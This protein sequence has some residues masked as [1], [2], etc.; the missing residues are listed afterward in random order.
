MRA[1]RRRRSSTSSATTPPITFPFDAPLTT[2]IDSLAR[3]MSNFVRR[4]ASA[5]DVGPG[6]EAA[7]CAAI[8][9]PG[10]ATLILPA[11]AAWG[12]VASTAPAPIAITPPPRVDEAVIADVAAAIAAAGGR[13]GLLLAGTA[14]RGAA[15]AAAGRIAAKT[16]ARLFSE[17]LIARSERGNG[18][19]PLERIP[20]PIDQARAVLADLSVLILVGAHEP[21]AFFAYPGKPSRLVPDGC[22]VV[23]LAEAGDAMADALE[24]LADRLGA[25]AATAP[26]PRPAAAQGLPTGPLT[27]DAVS[28]IA[29]AFL[30]EGAIVCDE[31]L[32]SGRR[33][34]ALSESGPQHDYLM[35]TGGAIGIG[36]P[37]SVGAAVACPDRKVVTLQADG[38]GMYTLQ[39]L[40]TT[41]REQLDIVVVVFANHAYA[42]LRAEMQHVGVKEFGRNADRMLSL[43]KPDLD[44]V[45][46]ARGMGVE[47]ARADSCEGFADLYRQALGRRGP[48]LIEASI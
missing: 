20:Y 17:V 3:P 48:F 11:D 4:I 40:W 45:S 15:L 34:Y 6:A 25:A 8:E 46:L 44:W 1:A 32:T 22:R 7:L 43:D 38:S 29:A 30:P 14:P 21:V 33:F 24:R 13:A 10:I 28:V 36:I 12:E 5:E 39:G 42:I 41:A 27:E 31:G 19:A 9:G 18:R 35:C 26:A 23:R 16:G 37:L 47:A 2:D